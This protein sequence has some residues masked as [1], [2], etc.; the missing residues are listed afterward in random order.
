[1]VTIAETYTMKTK[2]N[3]IMPHRDWRFDSAL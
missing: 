2:N 3:S 1:M